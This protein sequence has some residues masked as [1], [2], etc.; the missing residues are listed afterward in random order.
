[1]LRNRGSGA[2]CSFNYK[3]RWNQLQKYLVWNHNFCIQSTIE[4]LIK[5]LYGRAVI[6]W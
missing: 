3:K 4:N 1:M 2:L 5:V 6:A